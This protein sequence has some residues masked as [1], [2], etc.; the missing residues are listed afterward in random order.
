MT[1]AF[2]GSLVVKRVGDPN[3]PLH[4]ALNENNIVLQVRPSNEFLTLMERLGFTRRGKTS[5][6]TPNVVNGHT[7]PLGARF[8]KAYDKN[9]APNTVFANSRGEVSNYTGYTDRPAEVAF[10]MDYPII[11]FSDHY[12]GDG[13]GNSPVWHYYG[14]GASLIARRLGV[15]HTR[16]GNLFSTT[17]A[18]FLKAWKAT[19]KKITFGTVITKTYPTDF[20]SLVFVIVTLERDQVWVRLRASQD[21]VDD[22]RFSLTKMLGMKTAR[23]SIIKPAEAVTAL[24][25]L[26]NKYGNINIDEEAS[27]DALEFIEQ[28]NEY[29]LIGSAKN[30]PANAMIWKGEN[31][32]LPTRNEHLAEQRGI[33]VWEEPIRMPMAEIL[34]VQSKSSTPDKFLIHDS[35]MDIVSMNNAKI[36]KGEPRLKPFQKEAV[37]LHLSTKIGY[38]QA[39]QP[40][41]GK[42]HPLTTKVLTPSGWT[43]VGDL[44]PGDAIFG[45]DGKPTE[46][47]GVF[48]RGE[49]DVFRVSFNDGTSVLVDGDHLWA[50]QTKDGL[51]RK[52]T[53]DNESAQAIQLS[54]SQRR[55]MVDLIRMGQTRHA[56]AK[57]FN[58]SPTVASYWWKR[59]EE[60]GYDG[61]RNVNSEQYKVKSTRELSENLLTGTGIHKWRIPMTK[62]V[63]Y[64]ASSESLLVPAY[65][66][67][68]IL[69]DGSIAHGVVKITSADEDLE[70][71]LNDDL[72]SN[73]VVTRYDYPERTTT[74]ALTSIP[75]NAPNPIAQG[76]RSYDLMG[77]HSHTKFIPEAYLRASLDD[78]IALFQG[79][80]DSDGYFDTKRRHLQWG[81]VSERLADGMTELVQSFGGTVRRS[82]KSK[83]YSGPDGEK[84]LGKPYYWLAIA[85]P[86]EITP[87]RLQRKI[88]GYVPRRNKPVRIMT[89]IEPAGREEVRCISV[90]AENRLYITEN[91]IVTHNTVVQLTAMRERAKVI[92]NYRGLVV[93]ESNL[94]QQWK[95]EQEKWFPE[96]RSVLIASAVTNKDA[97]AALEEALA[98]EGPVVII[99][100]GHNLL[101]ILK[102]QQKR[103]ADT[104]RY[105][106]MSMAELVTEFA[107]QKKAPQ[108]IA[109]MILDTYWNDLCSDESTTIRTGN[110]K[111]NDALWILRQNAEVATAL[112]GTPIN[113]SIDDVAR[114]LAWVRNDKNLFSNKLSTLYDPT[115]PESAAAMFQ[116]LG[117]I[118]FRRDT[119]EE[120]SMPDVADPI[121]FSI[122]PKPAE[123]ALVVAAE[124]ELRR[125]YSELV[126]ALGNLEGTAGVD[127]EELAATKAA[128]AEARG[129]WLGGTQLARMASSDAATLL[130]SDSVGAALLISQGLVD[131]AVNAGS[132][133]QE[134]LIEDLLPRIQRGQQALV[135]T[136]FSSVATR[137]VDALEENGIRA[138]EFTGRNPRT[139]DAGR[140]AFQNGEVDVLVLTRA[141]TRGLTLHKASVLYHYDLPWTVERIIQRTGRGVRIGSEN[142]LVESIYLILEG[143]VEQR[144]AE[145]LVALSVASSLVLDHSRGAD[146]SN[147][148]SVTAM[149]GLISNVVRTTEKSSFKMFGEL[150]GLEES[151]AA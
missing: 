148:S 24:A 11:T 40:G 113:T 149:K 87:F 119:S 76:L 48:P 101:S 36:F 128:L 145:H 93:V 68:V 126:T 139:R 103:E 147:N 63:E 81:S 88:D 144:M 5:W 38:L 46:V 26:R 56:T 49:L 53:M 75:A 21:I 13:K 78:R 79:L 69:G 102:E 118:I 73:I 66:L 91:H 140:V 50:V 130:D 57:Q 80:L 105:S 86:N 74:Y 131:N 82:I 136:E 29:V 27:K 124:R 108:S 100:T 67:G 64:D 35:L 17:N 61:L 6:S 33:H 15:P 120:E 138:R 72:D 19:K 42:G 89:S 32:L 1:V 34:K 30:E 132:S 115:D 117:P 109:K 77:T 39:C 125:C 18:T 60:Q 52:S 134:K 121:V 3:Q 14:D 135:F 143:T 22:Y 43:Q 4:N 141:G 92:E 133:K 58:V 20:S 37:G 71:L 110:S 104:E 2:P 97:L 28:A 55:E 96:A 51:K 112:T 111:Q 137:L 10:R 107:H 41:M 59:F 12:L 122:T 25:S 150:L 70:G 151:I 95:E 94:P 116:S 98:V 142:A 84:R 114:L 9:F 31:V 45:S 44:V 54:V 127:E 123:R 7:S 65:T 99:M 16:D 85:L 83:T 47:T 8:I 23:D 129:A 62:P 106:A 146:M 90:A